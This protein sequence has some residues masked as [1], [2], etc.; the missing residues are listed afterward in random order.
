MSV[1]KS[2]NYNP[3]LDRKILMMRLEE[4]SGSSHSPKDDYY[5]HVGQYDKLS[6]RGK[7]ILD[8]E[9]VMMGF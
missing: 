3:N 2:G 8:R 7:K 5:I 6:P 1:K 9:F 4:K